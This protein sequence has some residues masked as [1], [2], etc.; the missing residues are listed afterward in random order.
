MKSSVSQLTPKSSSSLSGSSS[1]QQ[2]AKA[3]SPGISGSKISLKKKRVINPK[4]ACQTCNF[5]TTDQA[6]LDR[7][8]V[9]HE[10]EDS[11]PTAKDLQCR[12]LNCDFETDTPIGQVSH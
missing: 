11:T 6:K 8:I 9:V 2:A 5:K 3:S 1:V 4:Y 7:H 10:L 12:E